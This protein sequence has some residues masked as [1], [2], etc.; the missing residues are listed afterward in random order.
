MIG[1]IRNVAKFMVADGLDEIAD[2]QQLSRETIL[3]YAKNSRKNLS[4]SD[5]VSTCFILDLEK[6]A[7]KMTHINNRISRVINPSD[8]DKKWC[9]SMNDQIELEHGWKNESLKD[10]YTT[11]APPE[12]STKWMEMLQNVLRM[13][14]DVNGVPLAAL[15]C[16]RIVP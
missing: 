13:I 4:G 9:R 3:L 11:Q 2:I 8:I 7:F 5:I 1:A 10:L 15:I 14:R 12:N 6:A 16:K